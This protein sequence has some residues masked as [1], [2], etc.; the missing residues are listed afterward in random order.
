MKLAQIVKNIGKFI[1]IEK[2]IPAKWEPKKV[3]HWIIYIEGIDSFLL[4][5]THRPRFERNMG[6]DFQVQDLEFEIYDPI[7]PSGAQQIDEWMQDDSPRNATIKM[8][9][10]Y[11]AVVEEWHLRNLMLRSVD[12]GFLSYEAMGYLGNTKYTKGSSVTIRFTCSC[13]DA[14]LIY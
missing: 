7:D 14:K 11:G 5:E 2:M 3:H 4:K 12:F 9:D 8:L 6:G 13:E 10:P 1:P